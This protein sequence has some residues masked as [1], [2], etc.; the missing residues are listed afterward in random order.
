MHENSLDGKSNG[1]PSFCGDEGNLEEDL[2]DACPHL[3]E[4]GD[5]NNDSLE[6]NQERVKQNYSFSSY[7]E[8]EE[9]KLSSEED[10]LPLSGG[11]LSRHGSMAE[12]LS[13]M[14]KEEDPKH[15]PSAAQLNSGTS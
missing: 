4:D 14:S 8:G 6:F 2:E 15:L 5:L 12:H 7:K 10:A 11:L 9:A 1:E 13:L 3:S